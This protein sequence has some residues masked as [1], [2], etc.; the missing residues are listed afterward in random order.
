MLSSRLRV[1][2]VQGMFQ[3]ERSMLWWGHLDDSMPLQSDSCFWGTRKPQNTKKTQNLQS[4][5]DSGGA[6]GTSVPILGN[7]CPKGAGE[8]PSGG[9][10][11]T[12]RMLLRMLGGAGRNPHLLVLG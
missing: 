5:A 11:S 8:M 1:S 7:P 4:C 3:P 2:L 12:E 6:M 9:L 10:V